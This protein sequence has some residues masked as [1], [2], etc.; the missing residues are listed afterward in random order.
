MNKSLLAIIC[1]I[2]IGGAILGGLLTINTTIANKPQPQQAP[3]QILV[4]P[5]TAATEF[6]HTPVLSKTELAEYLRLPIETIDVILKGDAAIRKQMSTY[7]SYRFLPHYKAPGGDIVF[8]K[9]EV[10]KWLQYQT[11]NAVAE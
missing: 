9:S 10:D 1:S 8:M 11:L 6:T 7:D 2:I 3:S 5:A 4:P